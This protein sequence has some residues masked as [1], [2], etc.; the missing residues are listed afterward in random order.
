MKQ[1]HRHH[2]IQ[3]K[4]R[5]QL[6]L[7][8]EALSYAIGAAV[9][10]Y[11]ISYHILISLLTFILVGILSAI[12]I[13][14]WK[15]TLS[16]TSRFLDTKYEVLEYS[17]GLLLQPS[18]EV[19][20]L[21][22]LQQ[23]KIER[24]LDKVIKGTTPPNHAIQGI[25][26]GLA[27]I[28]LGFLLNQFNAID[29]FK[30]PTLL[31]TEQNLMEFHTYDSIETIA[32]KPKITKQSI[33]VT[34]PPYINTKAYSSDRMNIKAVEG[35]YIRWNLQFDYEVDSVLLQSTGANYPMTLKNDSYTN[36]TV[37]KYSGFYNFKFKDLQGNAYTS[38]LY[39]IEVIK[40]EAPEIKL[41]GIDPF[42]SFDFNQD[43][44][45]T[46]NALIT[47]DYGIADAQIIAT[48]SKGSGESVKFREEQLSFD[49]L[50][51][52]GSKKL[53]L[54]KKINLDDMKME[55]GDE[56]Y[57][58]IKTS[59]LK[60]PHP[61]VS[62]SETYFVVIKDTTSYE[63]SVTGNMGVDRMPDYFRSQ[64]QLII[65]TKK[66]I[67]KRKKIAVNKFKFESNELG[68][69]QKTLRLKYGT[70]M[71]EE[72]EMEEGNEYHDEDESNQQ[73]HDS[74]DPLAGFTHEHDSEN[75]HNLVPDQTK[76]EN[77]K[78][79]LDA[80]I[81]N[82]DNPEAATLF[83][84][85]LKVKLRKALNEMWDA[86]LYLRLYKPEKSLPYQ[87]RALKL[88]Q[89]IKNSARI[90]VHRIGFDPPPIKED[91]RLSGKL[92]EVS[93]YRKSE[94]LAPELRFPFMRKS[95][96]RLETLKRM[97]ENI[98]AKDRLLF[99]KAG[100]EFATLA[101]EFPGKYLKA[102]QQLKSISEG[103]KSENAL[104]TEVQK[105]LILAIPKPKETPNTTWQSKDEM[106]QLLIQTLETND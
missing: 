75:E 80:F 20:N 52:K 103:R 71:G 84:E 11:F 92:D 6:L 65:D 32:S 96:V 43:K 100:N 49:A 26:I 87:Y 19:S 48:V 40:D 73:E 2:I 1:N 42:T 102:L 57:F 31:K 16:A 39:S 27:M 41:I 13:K 53:N 33:S 89:D 8:I 72:S 22:K 81:H 76:K 82:H 104:Y 70:F 79:P 94:N 4:K 5:W 12:I 3:F 35:S 17:T 24:T 58:Y 106:T 51:I 74:E 29:Y 45:V 90:Y 21:A 34:Y 69:D 10:I 91:K 68:F 15:P 47:D 36:S 46:F 99:E 97:G 63:F 98:E 88:I 56:L 9:L 64:R 44:S 54:S 60:R 67:K 105:A 50:V 23:L 7:L 59:D 95:I 28:V 86:E 77:A 55:P 14:P 78:N 61:N 66:L 83:T 37:L 38:D 101:I 62:R 25:C 18:N 30:T 85:S 93:S